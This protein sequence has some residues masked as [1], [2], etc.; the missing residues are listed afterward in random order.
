[1]EGQSSGTDENMWTSTGYLVRRLSLSRNSLSRLN[2]HTQ[3][4]TNELTG[5]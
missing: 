2:N 4:D 3:H 1:M 5:L